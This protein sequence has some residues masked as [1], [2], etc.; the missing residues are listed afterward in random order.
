MIEKELRNNQILMNQRTLPRKI[1]QIQK[2]RKH[3]K[4]RKE[5]NTFKKTTL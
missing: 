3:Q 1:I 4:I 2:K 5:G